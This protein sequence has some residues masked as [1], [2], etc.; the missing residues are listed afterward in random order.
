[1]AEQDVDFSPISDSLKEG[2]IKVGE[3]AP[4]KFMPSYRVIGDS[5]IPV[6][7][8]MGK[9]WKS[10]RDQ[11]RTK[12]KENGIL[13]AWKECID[14][15]NNDQATESSVL[16]SPNVS[17]MARKGTGQ[18]DDHI[19]TENI[20]FANVTALVPATYAKNPDIEVT[21]NDKQDEATNYISTCCER[22]INTLFHKKQS[23]GV[24]LKPKVRKA[25][26]M[27]TLTNVS[28]IEIGWTDK[29]TSSEATLQ[30]IARLSKELEKAKDMKKIE[31]VEGKL[32]A[33]DQ[34]IDVLEPA[35]PFVKFRH[36]KDVLRDPACTSA[37]LTDCRWLMIADLIP[38][39]LLKAVYYQ[40]KEDSNEYESIYAPTHVLKAGGSSAHDEEVNNF[41]LLESGSDWQRYGYDD[42]ETFK[43]SCYT[44]IWYVWDKVTR[45]CLMFHDLD[46]TYP[47]WVW[48]DP[49]KL[50]RFFPVYCLEFYTDPESDYARSE[51][52]YYLDQQDAI[53]EIHSERRRAIAWAR[54]NIMYDKNSIKD[55]DAIAAWL[56]GAEKGGAFGIELPPEKKMA[57]IVF[58]MPPPSAAFMQI[59][60]V[61]PYLQAI[62]RVS[63]VT[64]VMRGVEYKTNT[65]NKAIE[66]YE[67]QTQTR[68]DEKIDMIED[69]IGDIGVGLLELCV[70]KMDAQM[71]GALI[72]DKCAE[73]WS[74]VMPM[75]PY[76]FHQK[77]SLRVVG[78]SALKPTARSKKEEAMQV[79]QVLGQFGK[80]IPA[81]MLVLMRVFERAFDEVV[82]TE[83][84]WTMIRQGIE[85]QIAPEQ[86]EQGDP[87]AAVKEIEALVNQLPPQAKM[88]LGKAIS[89]GVPVRTAL[90]AIMQKVQGAQG[91]M[92][93]EQAAPS[94]APNNEQPPSPQGPPP[95]QAT[96][97][98]MPP[99]GQ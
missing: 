10:R 86:E 34:K 36:P 82:I 28:Y 41:S 83:E 46:W 12:L 37:D 47:V 99:Q 2:G 25:V 40:P 69:F 22:L 27:T 18:G 81:A 19:E 74:Q 65:T 5:K 29:E 91:A 3:E 84:D 85:K 43:S 54:K 24:N 78:G 8:S 48:D 66:T 39:N 4:Q 52:M 58:S 23:P 62:D 38:T 59:F 60:D 11:A 17:R 88:A 87:E 92:G 61:Q 35:G 50:S 21:P 16:G 70:Q 26:I 56:D 63:S 93:G 98:A 97:G 15:Y 94:G 55:T 90:T 73:I 96:N 76:Q 1:M 68:L 71:V 31:E 7:K 79:G 6:A 89:Q 77:F 75:E 45:R 9:L 33:L 80:S 44:K 64:N 49:Y 95:P 30:E 13:D 57:D 32:M 53:N 51:V 14:Y 42:E 72:E 67:G 20:V